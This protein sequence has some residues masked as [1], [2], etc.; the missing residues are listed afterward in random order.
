MD[1]RW[2]VVIPQGGV[3]DEREEVLAATAEHA[4]IDYCQDGRFDVGD[5]P[6][7]VVSLDGEPTR[8]FVM[9]GRRVW[10]AMEVPRG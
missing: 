10:R 1:K 7:L 2:W 9:E 4:A 8:H 5:K 3:D 6:V